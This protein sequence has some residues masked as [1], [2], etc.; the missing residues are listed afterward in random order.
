M[1]ESPLLAYEIMNEIRPLQEEKMP[2]YNENNQVLIV[3]RL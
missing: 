1:R 2:L 3:K